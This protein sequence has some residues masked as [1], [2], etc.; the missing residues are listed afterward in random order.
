[1]RHIALLIAAAAMT[2]AA[3]TASA[4]KNIAKAYEAITGENTTVTLLG[5]NS[6]QTPD[7][8]KMCIYQ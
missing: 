1:M 6:E 7:R 4:Q 5:S 8:G 2:L 3:Q